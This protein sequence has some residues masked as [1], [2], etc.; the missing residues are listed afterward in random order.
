[1]DMVKTDLNYEILYPGGKEKALTFSY[2]D[3]AVFDKRLVDLFDRYD[4]KGTFHLNFGTLG[5]KGFV[6]KED[7][8]E[9]YGKHEVAC[10]GLEHLFLT[11]LSQELL[12]REILDDRRGLEKLTG[13]ITT[14]M[15]YAFGVY[16]EKIKETLKALGIQYSRTVNST[17]QFGLPSDFLAWNPTCHHNDNILEQAEVFL[18]SPEYLKLPLFY[19]WGHSFEFEREGTWEIMEEFCKRIAHKWEVWYATNMEIYQYIKGIR[20]LKYNLDKTMVYN[21][22]AETIWFKQGGGIIQLKPGETLVF[23]QE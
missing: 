17:Y 6:R 11:H 23:D 3:G 19:I 1:M 8:A 2:D 22:S 18:N 7:V 9:I 20:S 21:P 14:G 13:K 15:S 12:I 5:D 10:H 4:L 16:D